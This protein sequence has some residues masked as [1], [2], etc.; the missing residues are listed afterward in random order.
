M[1]L[2]F[3]TNNDHKLVEVQALLGREHHVLSLKDLKCTQDIPETADT[4]EGN[5]I[6]KAQFVWD[7]FKMDCFADD[8]GLEVRA[9]DGAPGV[10]SARYAGPGRD[11]KSNLQKLLADLQG[12]SDR[13]ARFKTVI[14]LIREGAQFLFTGTVDGEILTAPRGDQGFG[15]DPLFVPE[16]HELTFAEMSP[17]QKNACSHRSIA[18]NKLVAFLKER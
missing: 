11:S 9:L 12:Q 6:Q 7:N 5:A 4:I 1:R 10:H 16:N 13:Q 3:A 15:Y 2:C 8:T 17:D 18:V 14:C